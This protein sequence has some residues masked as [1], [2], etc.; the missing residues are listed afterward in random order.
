MQTKLIIAVVIGALVTLPSFAEGKDGNQNAIDMGAPKC[1]D[2]TVTSKQYV[3][4]NI[5]KKQQII[6]KRNNSNTAMTFPTTTGGAPGER[7]IN[8]DLGSSTSDSGLATTGAINTALNGKQELIS[9]GTRGDVVLYNNAGGISGD[10]K[11][12]YNS[13]NSYDSQPTKLVE[14]QH[15]NDAVAAGFSAHITCAN[16]SDGCTLWTINPLSG[17]YVP[18]NQ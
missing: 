8:T 4:S 16:P 9:N 11:G 15:V 12:V 14:A 6:S 18:Q 10:S 2:K 3:D 17:T 1:G 5:A 13:S 7:V